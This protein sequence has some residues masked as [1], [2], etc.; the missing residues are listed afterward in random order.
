MANKR[1]SKFHFKLPKFTKPKPNAAVD[2]D[3]DGS[4]INEQPQPKRRM[5]SY[6]V[7]QTLINYFPPLTNWNANNFPDSEPMEP[8]IEKD[9]VIDALH[10]GNIS[11]FLNV[12]LSLVFWSLK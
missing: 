1:D 2:S 5:K 6:D 8:C 11:R 3:S 10:H 7:S 9:Y 4:S 12:S